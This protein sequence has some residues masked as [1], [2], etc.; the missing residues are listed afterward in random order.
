[1]GVLDHVRDRREKIRFIARVASD[2]CCFVR[3][4]ISRNT[5]LTRY[6][7]KCGIF[8]VSYIY[9]VLAADALNGW[10]CRTSIDDTLEGRA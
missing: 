7:D 5:Y 4:L 3:S 1:M 10:V 9:G 6:S 8:N 2:M